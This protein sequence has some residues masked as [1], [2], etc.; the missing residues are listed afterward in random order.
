LQTYRSRHVLAELYREQ[1]RAE[2]AEAQWR[3]ALAECPGLTAARLGLAGLL[4]EQGRSAELEQ[5]AG[6][7]R[8]DPAAAAE[9]DVLL[10]RA[11]LARK[12]YAA[13]R[14]LLEGCIAREPEALRPRVVLR[15]V[16]LQERGDPAAAEAALRAVLERDT[17]NAEA[18]HNLRVLLRGRP[19]APP[20]CERTPGG[21]PAAGPTREG[22]R[23]RFSLALIVR[24]EEANLPACLES[25]ADLFDEVV[26]VDTGSADATKE[27]AA[28][29]GA[30]V[31]DFPWQD[32]FAAA[33][34]AALEHAT[35]DWVFWLDA[36]DRLGAE[37]RDKV[38]ALLA[39]L[40][41]E[42]AAYVMK[43][44]CLPDAKGTETLV[45]HLRLFR[46]RPDVRWE[47]RVHEQIL[48]AARRSGADV[49]WADVVVHH[50]GYRDPALRRRRLER[51]LRL[52][53]LE[54]PEQPDN[55]FTLFNLG[56]VYQELG[57]PAE[58][59]PLFRASL[60][61]S[62]PG[63][64]IVR[65]LYALLAQCHLRLAQGPEALRACRAGLG[66]FPEDAELLV[67]EG[68]VRR[69]LGD[70]P[71]AR[72]CWERALATQPGRY[73]ASVH[74][75]LRG[76]LTRHN[77]AAL[78]RELGDRAAAEAHW[79]AALAERPTYEPARLGLADLLLA[80]GHWAEAQALADELAAAPGGALGAGLVR[81]RLLLARKELAPAQAL[82]RDLSQQ[83]PGAVE[84]R[85]LLSH[86][87]LQEGR[88][89]EAAERALRDVLALEP[90]HAE[91]RHNL[92]VLL[93]NQ[94]LG[95]E[96][97]GPAAAPRV[98]LL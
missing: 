50:T 4:L 71:G 58:A 49:R 56:Q 48:P 13:A 37:N 16:L 94:G 72:A 43:C 85:Q 10:A 79:R 82:L 33:R 12:D 93:R 15:Y 61:G 65:K 69:R 96:A 75:G 67:Q 5:E 31:Y 28:R 88:D 86:A 92:S 52:L 90:G 47:F 19:E 83:H 32:S 30:R 81:G 77:L 20:A 66:H 97:N 68:L 63:D 42:N 39:S 73:F 76:Y 23:P 27:V 7:L 54:Q 3:L 59:L 17:G 78:C 46:Y 14:A 34:N 87:L 41:Q 21:G 24:D 38:R 70:R 1:G 6:R 44:L 26:V 29:Y 84:P 80:G 51:D 9:A 89:W 57:R 8:Q 95:R 60:A 11:R 35:C 98:R 25:A 18:A 62:A 45:D 40:G 22:N 64:S 91:A 74:A 36:D 53:L 55:P 2:E